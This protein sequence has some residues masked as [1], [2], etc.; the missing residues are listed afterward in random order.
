ML[1]D[2]I[3]KI[4]ELV[5]KYCILI[6]EFIGVAVLLFTVV[7]SIIMLL[8]H[9]GYVRLQLAADSNIYMIP[10]KY[11]VKTGDT[12]F[13]NDPDGLRYSNYKVSVTAATYSSLTSDPREYTQASYAYD[14]L[15]YTN[16]KVNPNVIE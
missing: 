4:F 15:I 14:H 16:T 5:V 3:N 8:R 7:R 10:I 2:E 6:I 13:K 9:R 12:L 1:Y 11:K